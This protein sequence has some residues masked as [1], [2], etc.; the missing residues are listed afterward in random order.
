MVGPGLSLK[1]LLWGQLVWVTVR[2]P[3]TSEQMCSRPFLWDEGVWGPEEESGVCPHWRRGH[4][5]G[6]P[7]G[8]RQSGDTRLRSVMV[9]STGQHFQLV[10]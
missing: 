5:A 4:S 1:C 2:D 7:P 6:V 10:H 3:L 8:I 9:S